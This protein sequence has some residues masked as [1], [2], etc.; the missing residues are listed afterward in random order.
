MAYTS[1]GISVL[2]RVLLAL[3]VVVVNLQ[4][5]IVLLDCRYYWRLPCVYGPLLPRLFLPCVA[6]SHGAT[7]YGIRRDH[8]NLLKQS[9]FSSLYY[10]CAC[11]L[12]RVKR[13]CRISSCGG[14]CRL[15]RE[16]EP[17]LVWWVA[18]QGWSSLSVKHHIL[19]LNVVHTHGIAGVPPTCHVQQVFHL[20]PIKSPE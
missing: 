9:F 7:H 2:V 19:L 17:L 6:T 14:S 20:M 3:F 12:V 11:E 13:I 4:D 15:P 10:V 8:L 1:V 5:K 18:C 16:G